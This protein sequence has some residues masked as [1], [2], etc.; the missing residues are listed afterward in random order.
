MAGPWRELGCI[1]AIEDL[2]RLVEDLEDPPAGGDR[3]LRLADPHPEHAQRHDEHGE[4]QVEGEEGAEGERPGHDHPTC[5]EQHECLRDEREEGEQRHVQRSLP[6]RGER[7]LEDRVRCVAEVLCAPRLLRER[8]H[9]VDA[10][11]RLLCD[12]RD[13]R[14]V[15]LHLP[16]DGLRH[17]AVAVRDR[18]DDRRDREG[19]EGELPAVDDEDR[20]DDDDR[21]DVLR[22]EDEPVAQEEADGLEVDRRARH[23]L[24]RLAA[25]VEAEREPEEVRVQ[26]VPQVVLDAE[27]LLSRDDAPPVHESPADQPESDDGSDLEDEHPRVCAAVDLVDDD[28]SKNGHEDPAS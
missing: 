11:D 20:G 10:G 19:H 8:F 18:H 16:Q 15:L 6:I 28:A 25:V 9:D 1:P 13:L 14:E 24:A 2:F 21:D 5:R 4:K 12:R 27:R 17:L 3:A 26:L 7:P 22:E 23:E